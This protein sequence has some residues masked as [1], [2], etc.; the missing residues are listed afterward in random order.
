MPRFKV[1]ED[2]FM[3]TGYKMAV[4]P[5]EEAKAKRLGLFHPEAGTPNAAAYALF[6]LEPGTDLGRESLSLIQSGRIVLPLAK[7]SRIGMQQ[8]KTASLLKIK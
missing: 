5:E 4:S 1:G 8:S 7:L 3:V 6:G 2:E